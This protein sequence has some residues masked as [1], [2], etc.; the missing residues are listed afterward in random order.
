[1]LL[2]ATA[3]GGAL[4]VTR[5]RAWH[6]RWGATSAEVAG[7]M[8]GD[9]LLTRA[10]FV[11]TRA[12]SI[13]APPER[14]WPWIVQ[15]G[16]RRAGFY[17]YDLLD[18]LGRSS[19][20]AVLDDFQHPAVGDLAA[21]MSSGDDDRTSFRVASIEEPRSLVWHKPDSTWAW[22]LTPDDAGGTRLVTRL[23]ARYGPGPFWP[24]TVLLMEIG[25]F[26]MMRR[27]L[28]GIAERAERPV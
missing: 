20:D 9:E 27:M 3:V 7:A 23:K 22:R 14:V 11:A 24:I 5:Y 15:V 2:L 16:F 28:L 26:P 17:S 8:P 10:D 4:V 13:A 21:P 6:L 18:N 19:A 25:D 1:M 12:I